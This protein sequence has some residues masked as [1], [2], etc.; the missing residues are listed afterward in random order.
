M[1]TTTEYGYA[2]VD[3]DGRITHLVLDR[4]DVPGWGHTRELVEL[5]RGHEIGDVIDYDKHGI[6]R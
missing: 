1:E 3:A 4:D 2:L 5:H 6:E